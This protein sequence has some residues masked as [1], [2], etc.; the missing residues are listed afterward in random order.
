MSI[1][2]SYISPQ[3]QPWARWVTDN[4]RNILNKNQKFDIDT[5]NAIRQLNI[6]IPQPMRAVLW[7]QTSS[8]ITI[9]TAGEYVPINVA[10]TLDTT[11]TFN[12]EATG[13]PN[14]TGFKNITNQAR[15]V[16]M[17][18]SYDGKCGN[19][20][21]MGLKLALN[22]TAIDATEC[23]SFAGGGGQ[24]G[25]TFTHWIMRMEPDDEVTMLCANIDN[26][27]NLTID[28][29]KFITTAIP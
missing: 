12:M 8:V 23:Q 4:I 19:N 20:H 14:V 5:Y 3:S 6:A 17:F 26:T 13:S 18:A 1:P 27:T 10:G 11:T 7:N 21:A 29:F 28:R 24:V 22:G 16:M 9:T 15:T 25:K 2:K